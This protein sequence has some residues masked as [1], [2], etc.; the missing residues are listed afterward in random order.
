MS[1]VIA[2][3]VRQQ[4]KPDNVE[5]RHQKTILNLMTT[6]NLQNN[7]HDP[8]VNAQPDWGTTAGTLEA[9]TAERLLSLQAAQILARPLATERANHKKL[10]EELVSKR[11]LRDEARAKA[12]AVESKTLA[13]QESWAFP[14]T[15]GKRGLLVLLLLLLAIL[16][17][18]SFW[19]NRTIALELLQNAVLATTLTIGLTVLPVGVEAVVRKVRLRD[20][21]VYLCL[22]LLA[23][24]GAAVLLREFGLAS[25]AE[26]DVFSAA[27]SEPSRVRLLIGALLLEISLATVFMHLAVGLCAVPQG[28]PIPNPDLEELEARIR[29]LDA[30]IAQLQQQHG[31]ACGRVAE[32]ERAAESWIANNVAKWKHLQRR[33]QLM[34]FA[35]LIFSFVGCSDKQDFSS[36]PLPAGDYV[37]SIDPK[38]DPDAARKAINNLLSTNLALPMTL[39]V[40]GTDGRAVAQ[41]AVPSLLIDSKAARARSVQGAMRDIQRFLEDSQRSTTSSGGI[42]SYAVANAIRNLSLGNTKPFAVFLV[43]PLKPVTNTNDSSIAKG[44]GG[45]VKTFW[46]DTMRAQS[47]PDPLDLALLAAGGFEVAIALRDEKLFWPIVFARG[48]A[49]TNSAVLAKANVANPVVAANV[50]Q[51][52]SRSNLPRGNLDSPTRRNVPQAASSNQPPANASSL[53][54]SN[55]NSERTISDAGTA[56]FRPRSILPQATEPNSPANPPPA[57]QLRLTGA[58]VLDRSVNPAVIHADVPQE[59]KRPTPTSASGSEVSRTTSSSPKGEDSP[60]I[61]TRLSKFTRGTNVLDLLPQLFVAA[62]SVTSEAETDPV[63]LFVNLPEKRS[64][65]FPGDDASTSRWVWSVQDG[66]TR[67]CL[68]AL[69]L[70]ATNLPNALITI[71]RRA[72]IYADSTIPLDVEI[73][74]RDDHGHLHQ[75]SVTL[76][77]S[78]AVVLPAELLVRERR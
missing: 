67:E 57:N 44:V 28:T 76:E 26:A 59:A 27:A 40:L 52:P 69:A 64:H 71:A 2:R 15:K 3:R 20:F 53:T 45:R 11:G 38:A 68:E 5:E 75:K 29:E 48:D 62:R 77:A 37:V 50:T 32:I 17:A 61:R 23:T 78:Q 31:E 10:E 16:G 25:G 42:D 19:T 70:N 39:T 65:I 54:N 9:T 72:V 66:R 8:F 74:L 1:G 55:V 22:L 18:A 4:P 63:A 36:A 21:W 43:G 46:L 12:R 7:G 30:E 33:A 24:I 14:A 41:A 6:Q 35:L 51:S 47:E 13:A 73:L 58:T 56:V 49:T 34:T 60:S